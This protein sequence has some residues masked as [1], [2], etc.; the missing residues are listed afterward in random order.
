MV[1]WGNKEIL[2]KIQA[3]TA[4]GQQ[5]YALTFNPMLQPMQKVNLALMLSSRGE[6]ETGPH[7][8]P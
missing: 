2:L 1:S 7:C 5:D 4:A 3:K 6:L 8:S